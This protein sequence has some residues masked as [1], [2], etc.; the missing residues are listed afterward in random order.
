MG[1]VLTAFGV[2]PPMP[3]IAGPLLPGVANGPVVTSTN[4]GKSF[5]AVHLPHRGGIHVGRVGVGRREVGQGC[6]LASGRPRLDGTNAFV[7]TSKREYL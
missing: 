3:H 4:D 7:R 6:R 5:R 2:A 1:G